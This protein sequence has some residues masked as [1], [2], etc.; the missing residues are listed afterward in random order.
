MRSY[1]V[2]RQPIHLNNEFGQASRMFQTLSKFSVNVWSPLVKRY[3]PWRKP[4]RLNIRGGDWGSL[5]KYQMFVEN[6]WISDPHGR[7][8]IVRRKPTA[9]PSTATIRSLDL[10]RFRSGGREQ[11]SSPP[12]EPSSPLLSCETETPHSRYVL[13]Q[14]LNTAIKQLPDPELDRLVTAA[15]EDGLDAKN[16][17]CL[18]KVNANDEP[19]PTPLHCLRGS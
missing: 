13:P 6:G 10:S 12:A 16:R 2:A 17:L 11:S 14:D 19:K 8:A 1:L 4:E 5:A 18:K 9:A 3:T 15:L 7:F